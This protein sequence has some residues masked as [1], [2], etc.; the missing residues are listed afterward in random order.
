MATKDPTTLNALLEPLLNLTAHCAPNKADFCKIDGALDF[1]ISIMSLPNGNSSA[2]SRSQL[3]I[4]EN[5]GGILR[6][7]SSYLI[8]Q[9]QL[10]EQIRARNII[11]LLLEQLKSPSFAIV[12]NACITLSHFSS[13]SPADQRTMRDLGAL[14]MLHSLIGSKHD[15]IKYGASKTFHNL[16]T[17]QNLA[18]STPLKGQYF[19]YNLYYKR[20]NCLPVESPGMSTSY[21]MPS[22]LHIRKMNALK[23][24]FTSCLTENYDAL[25]LPESPNLTPKHTQTLQRNATSKSYSIS[26]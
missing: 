18:S 22:S 15:T 21:S 9:E 20:S 14:K 17:S 3:A 1:L 10:M 6:N 16:F 26:K 23:S 12:S 8:S 24:E 2:P 5:S 11:A 13:R 4:V 19:C 25:L 7:V